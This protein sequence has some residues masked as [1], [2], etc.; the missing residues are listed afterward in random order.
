VTFAVRN[1]GRVEVLMRISQMGDYQ[2][3]CRAE[4]TNL[5]PRYDLVSCKIED[6]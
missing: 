2:L 1:G 5:I 6:S 4:R 3:T